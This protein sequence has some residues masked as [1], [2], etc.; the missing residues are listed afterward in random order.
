MPGLRR[1]Q[2]AAIP[3]SSVSVRE[4]SHDVFHMDVGAGIACASCHGGATDDGHV[5]TFSEAGPC[6]TLS[7]RGGI[8]AASPYHWTGDLKDMGALMESVIQSRMGRPALPIG[9]TDAGWLYMLPAL[10][11]EGTDAAA[12][13]RGKLLFASAA[14]GCANCHTGDA[15]TTHGV[16]DVGGGGSFKVPSLRGV[17]MHAPLF[18][19]GCGL[20][21]SDLLVPSF[22]SE[23]HGAPAQLT[24][25]EREDLVAYVGSL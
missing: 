8:T 6:R 24:G 22:A 18:H 15:L 4:S 7:L 11:A 9:F 23:K 5:W 19:N 16:E 13:A 10:H 2:A 20:G 17:A 12:V 25:R 1:V 21:L 3:L 14:I